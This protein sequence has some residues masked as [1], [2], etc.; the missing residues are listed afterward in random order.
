MV[1]PLGK[2]LAHVLIDYTIEDDLYWVVFLDNTGE[3]WTFANPDIRAQKNISYGR[4]NPDLPTRIINR[5][6]GAERQND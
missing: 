6:Y 3:C 4:N 2:G 1:T 5:V